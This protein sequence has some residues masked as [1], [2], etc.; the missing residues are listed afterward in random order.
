MY[1]KLKNEN[2]VLVIK[3]IGVLFKLKVSKIVFKFKNIEN[4]GI[5]LIIRK[6][7]KNIFWYFVFILSSF[8]IVSE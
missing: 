5:K 4:L 6:K 8:V 7:Y 2:I 3:V 1:V